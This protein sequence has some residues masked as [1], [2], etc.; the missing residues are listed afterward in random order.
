MIVLT[1]LMCGVMVLVTRILLQIAILHFLPETK[2]GDW[3][4]FACLAEI[5]L[6]PIGL[7]ISIIALVFVLTK[8]VSAYR[9]ARRM[10][11]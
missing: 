3:T 9:T 10:G 2:P 6:W 8:T 1:Y 4:I 11:E 7:L 5:M